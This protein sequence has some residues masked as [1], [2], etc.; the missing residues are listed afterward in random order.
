[1]RADVLRSVVSCRWDVLVVDEAHGTAGDSDRHAAA[2]ALGARAA[3]VLLLTATPHNGDVHAFNALCNTGAHADPPLLF[4]RT[5]TD[6]RLGVGRRV[7]RLQVRP[8]AAE[9]RMHALLASFTIAVR[10]ERRSADVW[11]PLAVL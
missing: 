8:T 7:H 2:A 9:A 1:K 4:R 3:Y 11:L 6:V 10:D 5:R